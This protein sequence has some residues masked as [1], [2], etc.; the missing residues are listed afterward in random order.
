MVRALPA[1]RDVGTGKH[2]G[3]RSRDMGGIVAIG[4]MVDS[5]IQRAFELAVRHHQAGELAEAEGIYRE[6]LAQEPTHAGAVHHLGLIALQRGDVDV[7]IELIAKA[8]AL[9]P[10]YA[11]AHCNLG[12]ALRGAGKLDEAAAAYRE[13]IR[14]KGDFPEAFNGLGNALSRAGEIGRGDQRVSRGD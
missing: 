7:A 12:N 14:L 11:E 3:L 1:S 8:I 5:S 9:Q 2:F 13:A 10:Q 4:C 6:I